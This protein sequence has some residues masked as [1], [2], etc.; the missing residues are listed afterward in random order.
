MWVCKEVYEL[1]PVFRDLSLAMMYGSNIC[2]C[3][4]R[5]IGA[6]DWKLGRMLLSIGLLG[7]FYDFN[8]LFYNS[9]DDRLIDYLG[10]FWG[11]TKQRPFSKTYAEMED[12]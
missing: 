2:G 12:L 6:K 11:L 7:R 9:D 1:D 5:F 10:G 8:F 4:G 3:V